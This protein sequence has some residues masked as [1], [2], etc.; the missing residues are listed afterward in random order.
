MSKYDAWLTNDDSDDPVCSWCEGTIRWP[1]KT[2]NLCSYCY[3]Q[4]KTEAEGLDQM[5]YYAQFTGHAQAAKWAAIAASL[6]EVIWF[7][8]TIEF[9]SAEL[10]DLVKQDPAFTSGGIK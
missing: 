1:G 6:D 4:A 7:D 5:R 9:D 2:G 3:D 8:Y 10:F